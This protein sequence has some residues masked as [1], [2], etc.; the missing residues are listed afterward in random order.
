M[1]PS[2]SRLITLFV[3]ATCTFSL[4]SLIHHTSPPIVFSKKKGNLC[5]AKMFVCGTLRIAPPVHFF[6][7]QQQLLLLPPLE[8]QKNCLTL[9]ELSNKVAVGWERERIVLHSVRVFDITSTETGEHFNK[10][11]ENRQ[12]M[13]YRWKGGREKGRLTTAAATAGTQVKSKWA[14][15][16]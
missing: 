5:E 7:R 10:V 8:R 12:W 3:L 15:E 11:V 16:I 9:L 4:F 6:C 2:L 14:N 1:H 13:D